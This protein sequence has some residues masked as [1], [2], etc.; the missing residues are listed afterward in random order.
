[1]LRG[2]FSFSL[3]PMACLSAVL[4]AGFLPYLIGSPSNGFVG[5]QGIWVHIPE[6]IAQAP[7]YNRRRPILECL[8]ELQGSKWWA[9]QD[10]NRSLGHRRLRTRR[11]CGPYLRLVFRRGLRC[12]S[13]KGLPGRAKPRAFSVSLYPSHAPAPHGKRNEKRAEACAHQRPRRRFRHG[14]KIEVQVV[15]DLA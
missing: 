10:S 12:H 14:S 15:S 2:K 5:D 13:T 8:V 6:S 3:Q 7:L 11:R 9:P 1:M 4:P